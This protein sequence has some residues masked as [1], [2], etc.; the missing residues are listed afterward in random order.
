MTGDN[1]SLPKETGKN[2]YHNFFV[3]PQRGIKQ[4]AAYSGPV[5]VNCHYTDQ[6]SAVP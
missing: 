6:K 5:I 1:S 2:C 4:V 3:A